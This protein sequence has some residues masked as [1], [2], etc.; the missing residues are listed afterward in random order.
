MKKSEL[1]EQLKNLHVQIDL[2]KCC[3]NCRYGNIHNESSWFGI[4]ID[5]KKKSHWELKHN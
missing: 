4:C 5:C 3:A 2:M 1:E